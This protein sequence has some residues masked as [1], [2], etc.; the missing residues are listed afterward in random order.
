MMIEVRERKAPCGCIWN[1][2]YDDFRPHEKPSVT[3]VLFCTKEHA[4]QYRECI[5]AQDEVGCEMML[6]A[7]STKW[8]DAIF[9]NKAEH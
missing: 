9:S 5:A 6:N 3:P 2:I 1:V 4:E 7:V 8:S